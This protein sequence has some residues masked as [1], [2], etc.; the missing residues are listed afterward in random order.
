MRKLLLLSILLTNTLF[1]QT[2][3]NYTKEEALTPKALVVEINNSKQEDIYRNALGWVKETFLNSD[4]VIQST[5]ENNKIRFYGVSK[6]AYC[7]KSL[8]IEICDDIAYLID[9]EF[10]DGKYRFTPI[11]L[12]YYNKPTKGVPELLWGWRDFYLNDSSYYF[13]KKG[14]L[15]IAGK[16]AIPFIS[17]SLNTLNESLKKYIEGDTSNKLNSDW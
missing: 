14:D 7:I 11:S 12:K 6:N 13:K 9:L 17:Q 8:G 3:F 4:E 1:A 15:N 5:I 16:N 10:K 2:E